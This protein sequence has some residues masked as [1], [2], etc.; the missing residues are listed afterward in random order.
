M[1]FPLPRTKF[2]NGKLYHFYAGP[3]NTVAQALDYAE[4]QFAE[5]KL[6]YSDDAQIW[7]KSV[8]IEGER[9]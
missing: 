1:K 9:S 3:F 6:S 7:R 8:Y 4:S 2:L 5:G